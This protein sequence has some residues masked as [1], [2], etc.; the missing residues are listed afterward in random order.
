MA[1]RCR[2]KA[3]V[4]TRHRETVR[5]PDRGTHFH[6]QSEV[7]V[8]GHA[9]DDERLLRVFLPEVRDR[10]FDDV[11]QL[12]ND[13]RDTAEVRGTARHSLERFAHAGHRDRGGE[14]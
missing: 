14:A 11:E 5:L 7:Q 9:T 6:V 1:A 8:P 13:G 4:T 10:R 12:R 2:R 3:H